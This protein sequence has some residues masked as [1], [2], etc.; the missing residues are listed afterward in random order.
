M[1]FLTFSVTKCQSLVL[2]LELILGENMKVAELHCRELKWETPE[3]KVKR[4]T[5][6]RV[7]CF[8]VQICFIAVPSNF[9]LVKNELFWTLL[10]PGKYSPWASNSKCFG[11]FS[12]FNFV[13]RPISCWEPLQKRWLLAL[14]WRWQTIWKWCLTVCWISFWVGSH[15]R[16]LIPWVQN[17]SSASFQDAKRKVKLCNQKG[18]RVSSFQSLPKSV[19]VDA[20][21]W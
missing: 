10:V 13:T 1:S 14:A 19:I 4:R 12:G 5:T 20:R 6:M 21:P 11:H 17:S 2:I 8:L 15:C 7:P 3:E 16:E 9:V 18:E